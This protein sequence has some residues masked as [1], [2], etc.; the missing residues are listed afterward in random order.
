MLPFLLLV[1]VIAWFQGVFG[2][3]TASDI[4]KLSVIYLGILKFKSGIYDT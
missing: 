3:N 1:Y 4:P 2:I